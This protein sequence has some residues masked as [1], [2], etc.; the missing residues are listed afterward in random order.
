[1]ATKYRASAHLKEMPLYGEKWTPKDIVTMARAETVEAVVKVLN[2]LPAFANFLEA[3]EDHL[4]YSDDWDL[5]RTLAE[6]ERALK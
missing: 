1:M 6:V 2:A 3:A 4:G 5:E